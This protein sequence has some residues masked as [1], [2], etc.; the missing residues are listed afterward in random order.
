MRKSGKAVLGVQLL[1]GR[2]FTLALLATDYAGFA[3]T[4]CA[5]GVLREAMAADHPKV[6]WAADVDP[7]DFG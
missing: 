2:R 7:C 5:H 1:I 3:D 4:A 6:R